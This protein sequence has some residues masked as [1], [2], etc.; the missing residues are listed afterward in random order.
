[1]LRTIPILVILKQARFASVAEATPSG[2]AS[3]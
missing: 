2:L 1:M 3:E